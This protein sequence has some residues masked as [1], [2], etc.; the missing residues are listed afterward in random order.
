VNNKNIL[1]G[2]KLVCPRCKKPQDLLNYTRL[3]EIEE[4]SQETVPIYKCSLCKWMFAIG[5]EM[6]QEIF[7]RFYQRLE[8]M[9]NKA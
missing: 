8:E 6:P 9:L 4:Y 3:Q 7:E 1:Q 5:G 2:T